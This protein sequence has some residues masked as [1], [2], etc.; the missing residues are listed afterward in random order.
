[1]EWYDADPEVIQ[2][3]YLRCYS[4]RDTLL[5]ARVQLCRPAHQSPENA[6]LKASG[7][8][9]AEGRTDPQ[10][11]EHAAKETKMKLTLTAN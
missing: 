5:F 10:A 1:M 8:S 7:R 9:L 2:S 11:Q 6:I 3:I 4:L